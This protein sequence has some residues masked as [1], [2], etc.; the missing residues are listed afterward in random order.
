MARRIVAALRRALNPPYQEPSVHFHTADGMP[1][2]C[3][4]ADCARP[5]LSV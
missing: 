5:R 3:Y 1:E 2:V 4:D